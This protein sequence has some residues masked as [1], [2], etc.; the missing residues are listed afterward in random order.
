MAASN[1]LNVNI[2]IYIH[3]DQHD[4]AVK[5]NTISFDQ[6][7]FYASLKQ[8]IE[9]AQLSRSAKTTINYATAARS[10]LHFLKQREDNT[11]LS[12]EV[13]EQYQQWL[14]KQGLSMNTISC[15]MRSLRSLSKRFLPAVEHIFSTAFTGH[16]KTEKRAIKEADVLKL[17][18]LCLPKG[19]SIELARDM[20]L[21]SFY[22]Q[23]MPFIDMAHLKKTQIIGNHISYSR[24]KTG[25]PIDIYIEACMHEIIN[26][27]CSNNSEYVF[28]IIRNDEAYDHQLN[29]Y[30]RLLK[31]LA[32]KAG[33]DS[34][35]TSYVARHTWATIA[36]QSNV[37][38]SVISKA[39]GHTNPQTTLI[40]IKEIS[41]GKLEKANKNILK[42][43]QTK[44]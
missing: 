4:D 14:R 26:R 42:A 34:N 27:Y 37:E 5:R 41:D 2:H 36:Y 19:S 33:L 12:V 44:K 29:R 22:A 9:K 16:I 13:I 40:Y 15:Y 39:L 10:L 17:Q 11:D 7:Q 25:Q 24:H 20:F 1:E 38:L 28:P 18:R 6:E 31:Q 43:F 23:G 35:I 8:A 3:S 30:N 32:K 21:F